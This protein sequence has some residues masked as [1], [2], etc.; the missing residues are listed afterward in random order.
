MVGTDVH[1]AI[2][3]VILEFPRDSSGEQTARAFF[4]LVEQGIVR[5]YDLVV[6]GRRTDGTREI[7]DLT[8]TTDGLGAWR[9]FAGARSGLIDDDD[10][11][12]AAEVIEPGKLGLVVLY[13]N[14]WA[15]PFVGA[16]RSEGG[17]LVASTRLTAQQIMD[18]L[19]AVGAE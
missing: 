12:E 9:A 5:V 13:E 15:I 1:G 2:D 6:V 16:V 10:A 17:D 3:L 11:V 4:D 19:D 8:G 18:A 14:A 7:V